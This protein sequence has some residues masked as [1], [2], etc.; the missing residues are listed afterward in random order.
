LSVRSIDSAGNVD[1]TPASRTFTVKTAAVAVS[2]SSLVVTAA[3]GAKDNI[4]ITRPSAATIRVMDAPG[5][6]Y[7]GSGVH[8]GAGCTRVGDY[9]ADCNAD[10]VTL[11]RVIAGGSMDQVQN[12]TALPSTLNGGAANDVLVG[13][14][15]ADTLVGGPGA[16]TMKGMNGNDRLLARDLASDASINCDGGTHPGTADSADLDLLP[17][18]SAV[19]GCETKTRH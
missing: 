15:Q 1:S 8:T 19:T 13:G 12:S 2:G 16:D 18:D 4:K 7:T 10:G 6:A 11:I 3:A 9:R 5:G 14:T 17:K